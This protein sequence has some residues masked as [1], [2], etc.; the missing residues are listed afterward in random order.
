MPLLNS[1]YNPK[2]TF[3][4]LENIW[5][6]RDHRGSE[7][8]VKAIYNKKSIPHTFSEMMFSKA[9][10]SYEIIC[11]GEK[12]CVQKVANILNLYKPN[13]ADNEKTK[14]ALFVLVKKIKRAIN[15]NSNWL[16]YFIDIFKFCILCDSFKDYEIEMAKFFSNYSLI[17]CGKPPIIMYCYLSDK[18]ADIIRSGDNEK[19]I[20]KI[21][22]VLIRRTKKFNNSHEI[23]PLYSIKKA[24]YEIHD[25]LVNEYGIKHLGIF[26][27]YARNEATKYSD[28]DIICEVRKDFKSIENL[29]EIIASRIKN[30]IGIDVDVMIDDVT[31]DKNQIPVDM[32]KEKIFL[33]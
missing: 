1:D 8:C 31:Y 10:K 18:M 33:F 7:S 6:K 15:D 4:F 11:N 5:Q 23:I 9:L 28:L 30:E 3:R 16:N 19:E 20:Y 17:V 26:G 32:F 29:Q 21:M 13:V 22:G 25:E 27:S 24:I 12:V 14:K 2:I